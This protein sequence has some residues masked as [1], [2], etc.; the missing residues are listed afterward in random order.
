MSAAAQHSTHASCCQLLTS[1]HHH[2]HTGTDPTQRAANTQAAGKQVL[3]S[4]SCWLVLP[5]NSPPPSCCDGCTDSTC[6]SAHHTSSP[7]HVYTCLSVPETPRQPSDKWCTRL[8]CNNTQQAQRTSGHNSSYTDPPHI[9][10][11]Q[12]YNRCLP[13]GPDSIPSIHPSI[14]ASIQS[15]PC[16]HPLA[17][18]IDSHNNSCNTQTLDCRLLTRRPWCC[19]RLLWMLDANINQ[20][21]T[22]SGQ[23]PGGTYTHTHVYIQQCFHQAKP[24]SSLACSA[25]RAVAQ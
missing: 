10:R 21:T 22:Q 4:Q 23:Q 14:H 2:D 16:L 6:G 9:P 5:A 15:I 7:A 17:S 13:A 8:C 11:Q 12:I 1:P 24:T 19:S 18:Q 20:H 25:A 3:V